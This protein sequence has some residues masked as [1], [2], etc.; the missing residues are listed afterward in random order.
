MDPNSKDMAT[1]QWNLTAQYQMGQ[2]TSLSIG[3]VANHQTHLPGETLV[4]VIDPTTG[5]L[6]NPAFGGNISYIQTVDT[7]YYN[8]LQT[9]FR[10]RLSH[11][12]AWDTYY[13]WSHD[14]GL[15]TGLFEVSAAVGGGHEQVQTYS[16]RNLN[17]YNMPQD[18]RHQFT[19]DLTYMLPTLASA[20]SGMRNVFGGWSTSGILRAASGLP[21]NI[22]TGGDTGDGTFEQ[23]PNLTGEPIYLNAGAGRGFVNPAAFSVPTDVDPATGLRLGYLPNNY[24]HLPFTLTMDWGLAK[25]FY[26]SERFNVEFRADAFNM[27]NHPV[28]SSVVGTLSAP[29]FGKAQGASDPREIQLSLK[30]NF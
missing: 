28:F 21:F 24:V 12:L 2:N 10:H 30:F 4:N 26:P 5:L 16:N 14:T 17:R 29:N 1:Q 6:Q 11:N 7:A 15:E 25:K 18:L 8:S 9:T 27:L 13:T 20:S 3:Y 19:T 23:R 22:F